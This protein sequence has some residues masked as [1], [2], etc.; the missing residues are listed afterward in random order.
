MAVE[1]HVTRGGYVTTL[2]YGTGKEPDQPTLSPAARAALDR[3]VEP[4]VFDHVWRW[5]TV[6]DPNAPVRRERGRLVSANRVEHP[7]SGRAGGRCRVVAR[8]AMNSVLV[9]FPDGTRVV[10]SRYAVRLATSAPATASGRSSIR[11]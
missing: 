1:V 5:R 10:T 6:G 3:I 9:E 2:F 7:L 4:I 8:G 11:P